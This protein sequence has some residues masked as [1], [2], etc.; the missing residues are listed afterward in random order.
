MG[1][2]LTQD[3]TGARI[4]GHLEVEIELVLGAARAQARERKPLALGPHGVDFDHGERLELRR[5]HGQPP[6]LVRDT[7]LPGGVKMAGRCFAGLPGVTTFP[8]GGTEK[9][10]GDAVL[11]NTGRRKPWRSSQPT[12]STPTWCAPRAAPA[13]FSA[14]PGAARTGGHRSSRSG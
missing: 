2:Q 3:R 13:R 5:L 6:V 10:W 4:E 7:S 11:K 8:N 14:C 12:G 9:Q 1:K